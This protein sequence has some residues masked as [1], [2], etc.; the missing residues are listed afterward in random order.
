MVQVEPANAS[1]QLPVYTVGSGLAKA[2]HLERAARVN[3][4]RGGVYLEVRL[5][6]GGHA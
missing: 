2:G 3:R 6:G 1:V 5:S 4:D